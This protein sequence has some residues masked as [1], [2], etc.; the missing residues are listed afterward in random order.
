MNQIILDEIKNSKSLEILHG[1]YNKIPENHFHDHIYI[2]YDLRT[3]LGNEPKIYTEIGSY[4]GHSASLI[5]NHPYQTFVNCIDPLNLDKSHYNGSL[6][7]EE[8]LKKNLL[9]NNYK[10]YKD[11]STNDKLIKQLENEN[12]K[13]DILF[14]DGDHSKKGVLNDF[15]KYYK[16]V[17]KNGYIIFDDYLDF[18]Y[19]PDVNIA[20]KQ[21]ENDIIKNNLPFEIIGCLPNL[22][23]TNFKNE[24][25]NEF[26]LKV[27]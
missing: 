26:I 3:L 17:N 15:Y 6:N 5:F 7:Q 2:L 11:F 22:K 24:Y 9:S 8:T 25:L 20:V 21:I 14:I 12:F 13:T 1:I 10:I 18:K 19:S 4:V 23:N 27:L 16:F